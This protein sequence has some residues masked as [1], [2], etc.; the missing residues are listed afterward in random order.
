MLRTRNAIALLAVLAAV[1]VA[2]M[3]GFSSASF[4][5][6]STA[7]S[8]SVSAAA[9]WTPPTVSLASPGTAVKDTVTL[10]ATAADGE[11]GIA[12]VEVQYLPR[13]GSAWATICTATSAPYSCAWNTKLGADGAYDLR[14]V[15]TDGSGYST[16]SSLVSTTVAN[17]LLVVLGDP[18]DVVRGAVT[19]PTTLY[20][21]GSVTY[22]VR[23]EYSPAGTNNWRNV[24]N[25]LGSPYSCSW[26]TTTYAN[27]YFDLRA[28]AVAGGTTHTSAVV[29]D[30][31]VDNLAPVLSMTDPGTPLSGTRT[32]AA[33][34]T[35]AHSGIAQVVLQYA[36]T[37]TTTWKN[38]CTL[39]AE[40]YSCRYDTTT[41][42]DGSYGFRAVATDVAGNTTTSA[43][44][45]NRVV[46][47]TVSSVAVEDPGAFVSG[48]VTLNATASST[49]GVTSVTIQRAP[50][51]TTT[52]TDVCTDTTAPYTCAW[53]TTTVTD[54]LY[55][56]RAVLV[57]GQAR[58]TTSASVTARRVDNSLLKAV[59]VQAT[60]GGTTLGRLDTGDSLTFTY[61]SQV[62]PTSV[63]PGWNGSA[64][65]VTVR[66][67]DGNLLGLGNKGDTLDVQRAGSSVNLG[68]VNLNE[69]YIRSNRTATWNGTLVLGTR[70]VNGVTQ[71]TVTLQL[72]SAVS[73]AGLKAATL[74]AAM[75]WTPSTS[76][77]DLAAKPCSAVPVTETGALDRDF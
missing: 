67:R 70:V 75:V 72:G 3:P 29:A 30:V 12:G 25:N 21:A 74:N 24:C 48:T 32:F 11:S 71:S 10:T 69:E 63:S 35:D 51:G 64:L 38:L 1:L 57:D 42:P 73:V 4:S 37:G 65:P 56:L 45:A 14:A 59:D 15:A 2:T 41:I 54:G 33:T 47:N 18:G 53:D 31:L 61:S 66:L 22:T 16:T 17:N 46:D 40:P 55:D 60:N 7:S 44:V 19:L 36:A 26:S 5:S 6:K 43:T 58:A 50:N 28:V 52:W 9:D 77:T 39:T 20:N 23:V 68:S 8:G 13:N 27:D 76:V 34:A 62:A 49:A